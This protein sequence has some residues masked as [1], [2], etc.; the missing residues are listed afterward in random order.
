MKTERQAMIDFCSSAESNS[1]RRV[2]LKIEPKLNKLNSIFHG[3][4]V[5]YA[6]MMDI[7][8][9]GAH[10]L[11]LCDWQAQPWIRIATNAIAILG[12]NEDIDSVRS[13]ICEIVTHQSFLLS[14]CDLLFFFRFVFSRHTARAPITSEQLQGECSNKEARSRLARMY[15]RNG[16]WTSFKRIHM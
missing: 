2:I 1:S 4:P 12:V 15:S 3:R 16:P 13:S 6:H 14:H 11:K 5:K 9:T 10:P 7:M 8:D